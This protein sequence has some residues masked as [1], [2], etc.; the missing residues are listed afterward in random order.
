[1][2]FQGPNWQYLN[3]FN[4]LRQRQNV[5]HSPDDIFKCIFLSEN[6]WLLLRISLKLVPR[7]LI[8]NIPALVQIMARCRPGDKPLSGLMMVRLLMHIYV[9][10]PQ[11]VKGNDFLHQAMNQITSYE[12]AIMVMPQGHKSLT[13]WGKVMQKCHNKQGQHWFR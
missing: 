7:G 13:H 10:R 5:R 1:M 9:T 6:V 8:N 3:T 4:T 11:W 2:C 12:D